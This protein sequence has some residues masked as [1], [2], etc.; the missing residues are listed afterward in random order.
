MAEYEEIIHD[1]HDRL[2]GPTLR[3][4]H[5]SELAAAAA[6]EQLENEARNEPAPPPVK[7]QCGEAP[8]R[9]AGR[10]VWAAYAE[11]LGVSFTESDGRDA[12]IT[13]VERHMEEK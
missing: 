1:E 3:R 10:T 6:A 2:Y 9:N 7:P 11:C 5:P 12:I 8:L 13:L 4:I